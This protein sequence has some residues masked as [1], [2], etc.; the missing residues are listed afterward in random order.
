[1]RLEDKTH[2]AIAAGLGHS[3][4]SPAVLAYKML[5]ESKY[6]NE[7][8][9]QYLVNY[10]IIMASH[11]VIPFHLAGVHE[12]CKTLKILLEELGLTGDTRYPVDNT[13]YLAV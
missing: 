8:M 1:M 13:E 12:Q 10:I 2:K 11:P 4:L 5:H 3:D 7:S 6:V 9:I